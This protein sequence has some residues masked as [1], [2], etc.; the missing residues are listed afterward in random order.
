MV[1]F[2]IIQTM[3]QMPGEMLFQ[4]G[5]VMPSCIQGL[6]KNTNKRMLFLVSSSSSSDTKR[7]LA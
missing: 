3:S 4:V 6:S 7:I 2:L 5:N 1:G